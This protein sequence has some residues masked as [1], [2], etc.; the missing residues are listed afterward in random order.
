MLREIDNVYSTLLIYYNYAL[1]FLAFFNDIFLNYNRYNKPLLHIKKYLL[2]NYQIFNL[3][4]LIY[5][6]NNLIYNNKLDE[7]LYYNQHIKSSFLFI[8]FSHIFYT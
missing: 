1:Y 7:D 3:L 6:N 8:H 2:Q 4:F 5:E